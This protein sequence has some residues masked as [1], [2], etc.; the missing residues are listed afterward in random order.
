LE[1]FVRAFEEGVDLKDILK[2]KIDAA[3]V[4]KDPFVDW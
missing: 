2:R 3:I 4:N 1:E